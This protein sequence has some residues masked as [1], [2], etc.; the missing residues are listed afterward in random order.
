MKKLFP[1][2][3]LSLV[4][5][6]CSHLKVIPYSDKVYSPTEKV[7][8][9]RTNKPERKYIEIAQLSIDEKGSSIKFLIEEAKELGADALII[10]DTQSGNKV[11]TPVFG[12]LVTEDVKRIYAVAIKYIE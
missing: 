10:L 12:V 5:V 8:I 4:I 7:E 11:T 6:G 2:L 1:L 3:F 9:F